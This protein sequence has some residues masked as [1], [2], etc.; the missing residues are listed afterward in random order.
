[1]S[2]PTTNA[3]RTGN[4]AHT[5]PPRYKTL[6]PLPWQFTH[7]SRGSLCHVHSDAQGCF[8]AVARDVTQANAAFIVRACNE[9]ASDKATIAAL[10]AALERLAPQYEKLMRQLD[11]DD[12]DVAEDDLLAA[13]RAALA[14]ARNP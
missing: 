8:E 4:D 13:A 1:M 6:T 14:A 2:T 9:Y 5:P 3:P 7:N 11:A 10:V 12:D